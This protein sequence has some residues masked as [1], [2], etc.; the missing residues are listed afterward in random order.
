MQ[1]DHA[2]DNLKSNAA[3]AAA[4]IAGRN[5]ELISRV[6]L[7]LR[8]IVAEAADHDW[9]V[10]IASLRR[11]GLLPGADVIQFGVADESGTIRIGQPFVPNANIADREHFLI[12]KRGDRDEL[13]ISRPVIGRVSGLLSVQFSRRVSDANGRMTGVGVVS[14]EP[15]TLL[16]IAVATDLGAGSQ[17]VLVGSDGVSRATWVEGQVRAGESIADWAAFEAL[18]RSDRGVVEANDFSGVPHVYAFERIEGY[19]LAVV[20]GMPTDKIG[21]ELRDQTTAVAVIGIGMGTIVVMLMALVAYLALRE[22]AALGDALRWASDTEAARRSVDLERRRAEEARRM[23]DEAKNQARDALIKVERERNEASVARVAAERANSVKT[24]FLAG[25]SHEL[26]TPLN[27]V[28]GFAQLLATDPDEPPSPGQ[29][30]NIQAIEKNGAI[31]LRLIEDVLDFAKIESGDF[32][33]SPKR[34]DAVDFL[35]DIEATSAPFAK[36]QGIALEFLKPSRGTATIYADQFRAGQ[37]LSNLVSNAIKY[38]KARGKVTVKV[39]HLDGRV[40]FE[41]ADTGLGIPKDKQEELF[42]PFRRLGRDRGNVQG[43]GIGLSIAQKLARRMGGDIGFDSEF[44]AGSRFWV[45]LPG[46]ESA[47]GQ[48]ANR[49]D[50]AIAGLD[51]PA[52][53]PTGEGA[54]EVLYVEDTPANTILMQRIFARQQGWRLLHAANAEAGVE[55]ARSRRPMAIIM[56]LNLPGMSGVEAM[57]VLKSMPETADI[58][59]MALTASASPSD[60]EKGLKAGFVAYLTK[61]VDIEMLLSKLKELTG[62]R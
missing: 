13:F 58:P 45:D 56:D 20:V 55:I 39:T 62:R 6:N 46:T 42:N 1:Q 17:L 59:I 9:N 38:N 35:S 52:R 36:L 2:R 51:V 18:Q 31:L 14:I 34:I 33:I 40:R 44:G 50:A 8:L 54:V 15:R 11:R 16:R 28:L 22:N 26:R 53:K 43:T 37:I 49:A 10:D 24:E 19:P 23:A 3:R 47:A 29:A 48:P 32:E 60:V 12:H 30:V 27:S 21:A 4:A 61:P 41:V 5:K 57:R 7:G 25:L